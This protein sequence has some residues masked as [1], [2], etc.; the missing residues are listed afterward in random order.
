[1]ISEELGRLSTA[2]GVPL[3]EKKEL[4]EWPTKFSK[5]DF[6]GI[7]K[8]GIKIDRTDWQLIF[9]LDWDKNK[10]DIAVSFCINEKTVAKSI[11]TE[12]KKSSPQTTAEFGDYGLSGGEIYLSRPLDSADAEHLPATQR[13]LI[14]EFSE[15]WTKVGGIGTFLKAKGQRN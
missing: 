5:N 11:F 6:N 10:M 4:N 8:L 14:R 12:F 3:L 7:T 9:H 1:V 2:M 15:L 13:E